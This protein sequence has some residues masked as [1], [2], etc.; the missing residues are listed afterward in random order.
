MQNLDGKSSNET[1]RYAFEFVVFDEL[2]EVDGEKFKR[3]HEVLSEHA[4]VLDSN[5][6]VR[7]FRVILLQMKQ[8]FQFDSG[9][10]LELLLVSNHLDCYDLSGLMVFAFECL[11]KRSFAEEV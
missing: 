9:L 3:Y 2:V 11:T 10:V 7:V 1:Q 6:V 8:D 5:D 4:V